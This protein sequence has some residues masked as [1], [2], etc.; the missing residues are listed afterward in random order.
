MNKRHRSN[1]VGGVPVLERYPLSQGQLG[2]FH[3]TN[4][5][6]PAPPLDI[7]VWRCTTISSLPVRNDEGRSKQKGDQS[8]HFR[9]SGPH[10][11]R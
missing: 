10:A 3:A 7:I 5:S 6:R 1:E 11:G 8:K 4:D 2:V 9:A